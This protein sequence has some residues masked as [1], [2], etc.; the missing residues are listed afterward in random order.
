MRKVSLVLI[1]GNQAA[2]LQ[3]FSSLV[4]EKYR[5]ISPLICHDLSDVS[6]YQSC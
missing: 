1:G 5:V 6:P 4:G 2:I 3:F